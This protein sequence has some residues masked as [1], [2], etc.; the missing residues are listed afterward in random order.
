VLQ[1]EAEELLAPGVAEA[2]SC[3]LDYGEGERGRVGEE[4]RGLRGGEWGQDDPL[5]GV[6]LMVVFDFDVD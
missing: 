1:A 6:H 5:P 4:L 2:G 3:I